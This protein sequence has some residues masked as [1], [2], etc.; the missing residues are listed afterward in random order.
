MTQEPRSDWQV[1]SHSKTHVEVFPAGQKNYGR[2][3]CDNCRKFLCWEPHPKNV[4]LRQRNAVNLRKLL[5]SGTL[6][7]W[8][9]GYCEGITNTPRLSPRQQGV[10]NELVAKHLLKGD[11]IDIQERNDAGPR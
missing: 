10:L 2:V 6:T 7:E 3:V 8:E 5:D 11:S 4:A 1:C 9:R